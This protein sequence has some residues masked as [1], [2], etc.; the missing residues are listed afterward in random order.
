MRSK[1]LRIV[2][3][4]VTGKSARKPSFNITTRTG[5]APTKPPVKIV[6]RAVD[7][8][9]DDF[10][11]QKEDEKLAEEIRSKVTIRKTGILDLDEDI[12]HSVVSGHYDEH[13]ATTR[14]A[15]VEQILTDSSKYSIFEGDIPASLV[16]G[17]FG[18]VM[19]PNGSFVM[20]KASSVKVSG[21]SLRKR[22]L[23]TKASKSVN[24]LVGNIPRID[25]KAFDKAIK[26]LRK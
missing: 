10:L 15:T 4:S 20:L 24:D 9:G 26:R 19:L 11:Q 7:Y 17:G 14:F 2:P 25:Q 18:Q 16:S 23:K 8:R 22:K 13:G 5:K 3:S 12:Y 21:K 6:K 1:T